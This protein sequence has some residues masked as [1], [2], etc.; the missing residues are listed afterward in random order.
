MNI[1]ICTILVS[2]SD[3]ERQTIFY[4]PEENALYSTLDLDPIDTYLVHS[5]AEA[6]KMCD[7]MWG[8]GPWWDLQW[9][10]EDYEEEETAMTYQE[11]KKNIWETL[12]LDNRSITFFLL[13]VNGEPLTIGSGIIDCSGDLWESDE[14]YEIG[15][16][17]SYE[18]KLEVYGVESWML[19]NGESDHANALDLEILQDA[20]TEYPTLFDDL[21]KELGENLVSI[22]DFEIDNP[23]Y[24]EPDDDDDDWDDDEDYDD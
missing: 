23:A 7:A 2:G 20:Y 6:V 3:T 15:E 18:E 17:A 9:I 22:G 10:I 13:E 8:A 11:F 16:G 4:V 1:D 14:L 12:D 24:D 5:V 19:G 21:L